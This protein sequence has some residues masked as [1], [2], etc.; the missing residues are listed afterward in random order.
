MYV[1][2]I[3]DLIMVKIFHNIDEPW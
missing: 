1:A 2:I 3:N